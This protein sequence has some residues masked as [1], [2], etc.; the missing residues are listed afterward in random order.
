[1]DAWFSG[2]EL[3][4]KLYWGIAL[5][6]S[7]VFVV[8]LISSFIGAGG[9]D[10]GDVDAEIESDTGAGYQFFTLKNLIAFFTIFGWSG[11]ASLEG[12]T[13][14]TWAVVISFLCGT[15]MMFIMATLFYYMRKLNSTGTL[16]IKNAINCVGEVY[17]TIGANRSSMGK[18][19]VRIQGSL[20]ELEALTDTAT[21]LKTGTVIRVKQ[22][23][24]NGILKEIMSMY[25]ISFIR[26]RTLRRFYK[27]MWTFSHF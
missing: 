12:G 6:A 21:S 11:I 22:V 18:V 13:S 16:N 5:I 14:K 17:L 25:W 9:G 19:H 20:R 10:M 7:A 4:E 3:F 2:L 15:A 1:M 24:E 8:I 26:K 23:T 27:F